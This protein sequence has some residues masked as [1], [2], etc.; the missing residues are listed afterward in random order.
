MVW[1]MDT[2]MNVVGSREERRA[3]RGHRQDHPAGGSYGRETA[4][5]QGVVHCIT[6]WAKR[7]RFNL[8]GCSFIVQGF[9]NVGSHAAKILA[10]MG[11]TLVAIGDYK[12]YIANPEGLN[13]HKLAEHV[14]DRLGRGLQA[15]AADQP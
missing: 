2:Y 14:R 10:K 11:A 4:T 13:P 9:G 1:I 8:N 6:E 3:P 12:G 7:R 5:G 15:L